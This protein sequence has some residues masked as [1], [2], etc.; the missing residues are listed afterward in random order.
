MSSIRT[1]GSLWHPMRWRPALLRLVL[2]LAATAV[3]GSPAAMAQ[4]DT[5]KQRQLLERLEQQLEADPGNANRWRL[6]GR[7]RLRLGDTA[8]AR[9]AF[10]Q[11]ISLD[12]HDAAAR[13]DLGRLLLNE[14]ETAEA[15]I[16]LE[17]A[18]AIAPASEY[19]RDARLVLEQIPEA[20][21]QPPIQQAGYE[22]R[23]FDNS[24]RMERILEDRDAS[25]F[26]PP[27]PFGIRL[28]TGVLYNTNVALSPTSRTLAPGTRESVQWYFS[29]DL[30][31]R[32]FD[33]GIW[34]AGTTFLGNFTLNEGQFRNL[35]LQ[36]W[37]PGVFVER[38]IPLANTVLSPRLQYDYTVDQFDGDFFAQR[39]AVT[40]SLI[41]FWDD[42]DI[43]LLYYTVDWSDFSGDG[44][45]PTQTSNDG[46]THSLGASHSFFVDRRFLRT[47]GGGID[48]QIVDTEGS[49]L[50]YNGVSLYVD[51]E[52]PV[53]TTVDLQ[54]QGGWGY[55][56]YPDFSLT[57]SRNENIWKAEARLRKQLTE[58]LS[59][60]AVLTW[61]R[62]DSDNRF[63]EAERFVGGV[64]L[65]FE[66]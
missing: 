56:D 23:E 54:L 15:A 4:V 24:D 37:Q 47:I 39:H 53:T 49:D 22:I 28:E 66:R 46:W 57:P 60:A 50:A 29:P 27:S 19:A 14:G 3:A 48:V 33:D 42:G 20:D 40:P 44:L 62:F 64:V 34:R 9:K 17:G 43:S 7:T 11:S 52:V 2:L 41:S 1:G 6:V 51:G 35:N 61:N 5:A 58:H 65:R 12:P 38:S 36:S 26:L 18:I 59:L 31:Y 13:H 32:F 45:I 21:R 63:F 55:R 30:E 10:E 16:Q 8:G 25:A